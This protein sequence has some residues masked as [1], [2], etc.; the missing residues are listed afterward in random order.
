VPAYPTTVRG[1]GTVAK[2][3]GS[4]SETGMTVGPFACCWT[5]SECPAVVFDG[6]KTILDLDRGESRLF[7]GCWESQMMGDH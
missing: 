1:L 2:D 5:G 3:P 6:R 7:L 4:G